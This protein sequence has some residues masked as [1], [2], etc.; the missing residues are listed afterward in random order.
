MSEEVIN[1]LRRRMV[2][3]MMARNLDQG[4]QRGYLRAVRSCSRYCGRSPGQL[5]FEDVR[6]FQLHLIE[7]GLAAGSVNS[8]MVGLRRSLNA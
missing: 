7:S 8:I 3:D 2:E 5:T 6:R 4:T 1:P